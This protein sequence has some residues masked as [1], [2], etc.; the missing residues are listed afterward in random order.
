MSVYIYENRFSHSC[1]DY[2]ILDA[3]TQELLSVKSM[4]D[5]PQVLYVCASKLA[6]S[7]LAPFHCGLAHPKDQY[8]LPTTTSLR[9]SH[10]CHVDCSAAL[11]M[12]TGGGYQKLCITQFSHVFAAYLKRNMCLENFTFLANIRYYYHFDL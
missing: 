6:L 12:L 5:T 4:L 8:L 11:I 10:C 3:C 9:P 1:P 2:F 7:K